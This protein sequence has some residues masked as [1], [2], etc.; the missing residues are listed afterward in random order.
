MIFHRDCPLGSSN[1]TSIGSLGGTARPSLKN[2]PALR[3][4]RRRGSH[5]EASV[6]RLAETCSSR[7]G[8]SKAATWVARC[9][10]RRAAKRRSSSTWSSDKRRRRSA[11]EPRSGTSER[12]SRAERPTLTRSAKCRS[13]RSGRSAECWSRTRTKCGSA[14]TKRRSWRRRLRA[15]AGRCRSG[16][17]AKP[18]RTTEP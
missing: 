7:S 11:A 2:T 6:G 10:E 13:G 12:R 4:L 1:I 8:G 15:K 9:P 5:R 16:S 3:V 17:R 18:R 14:S